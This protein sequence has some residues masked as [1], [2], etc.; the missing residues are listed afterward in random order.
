MTVPRKAELD[1]FTPL[2]LTKTNINNGQTTKNGL[3]LTSL[4]IN[5]SPKQGPFQKGTFV[6][7]S[8]GFHAICQFSG[9]YV[10]IKLIIQLMHIMHRLLY[11]LILLLFGVGYCSGISRNQQQIAISFNLSFELMMSV[12]YTC[13]YMHI[14]MICLFYVY[15]THLQLN[16]NS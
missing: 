9:E 10:F 7:Q 12:R 6:F 11:S 3:Q 5:T 16:T 4:K 15:K 2:R 13:E 14:Y 1:I 8:S